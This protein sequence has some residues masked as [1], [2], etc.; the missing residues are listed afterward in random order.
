MPIYGL[1][2]TTLVGFLSNLTIRRTKYDLMLSFLKHW[3]PRCFHIHK[4][5][6][7][8]KPHIN[9]SHQQ[10]YIWHYLKKIWCLI[11]NVSILTLSTKKKK[12]QTSRHGIQELIYSS[13]LS[14]L[15]TCKTMKTN[16]PSN[17]G[18]VSG[19]NG[20]LFGG[21]ARARTHWST[22]LNGYNKL[23]SCSTT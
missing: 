22:C 9:R 16:E 20:C 14:T 5:L 13:Y 23:Q 11:S 15:V 17:L 3:P 1:F 18:A 10:F 7:V 8:K 12:A 21:L 6:K 2:M 4:F 19:E